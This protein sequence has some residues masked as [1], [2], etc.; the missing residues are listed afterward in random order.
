MST[1]EVAH[2]GAYPPIVDMNGANA[3]EFIAFFNENKSR[4]E[5]ELK[6]VGCIK[7]RGIGINGVECFQR[8]VNSISDRFMSYIDGNSP[9]TKLTQ[10]VYTSTE[11]DK[12]QQITM[13][14]E[15]SYSWKWPNKLFFSCLQPAETGGETLIADS[16]E[17]L[18]RMEQEIVSNIVKRG[19]LYL[20]N[21]HGGDGFGPSWQETFETEDR[22]QVES[23]CRQFSIE[24]EWRD[25]NMLRLRQSSRGII[26][27]RETKERVWFNQI[28]QFHPCHLGED[29]YEGLM[30]IYHSC[31][32]F[33]MYVSFRDGGSIGADMVSE[34]LDTISKV[35]IAPSWQ[36]NELLFIDNELV[37]HGRNPFTGER[38][39]L[40]AMS[41]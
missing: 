19:L 38:K 20:R 7:F 37:C 13:H 16:R 36:K 28:D 23:Y 17:I 34:I 30:A 27:H 26:E 39:V 5:N 1:F 11:Y 31:D 21:L 10:S 41:E 4:L 25:K 2:K 12:S 3:E 32:N 18:S 15:L 9:R 8:I 29:I 6:E 40:V 24:F 22:H 35:T 14:N 33:P